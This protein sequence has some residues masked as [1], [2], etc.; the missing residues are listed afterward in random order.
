MYLIHTEQD[1]TKKNDKKIQQPQ[2]HTKCFEMSFNLFNYDIALEFLNGSDVG[3]IC[4]VIL[5]IHKYFGKFL[6]CL[7][8]NKFRV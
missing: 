4:F 8:S 7:V 2:K 6:T 3:Y 5:L 1:P